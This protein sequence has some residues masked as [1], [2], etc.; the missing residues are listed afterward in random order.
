MPIFHLDT[1]QPFLPQHV[2]NHGDLI[3]PPQVFPSSAT[4]HPGA[5]MRNSWFLLFLPTFN[6]QLIMVTIVHL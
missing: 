5:Q 2:Q 1:L 4:I 3:P 6:I